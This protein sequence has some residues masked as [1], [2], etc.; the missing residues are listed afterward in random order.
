VALFAWKTTQVAAITSG[1]SPSAGDQEITI[2]GIGTPLA[3]IIE[4]TRALTSG[5]G[6]DHAILSAGAAD[7]T[8]EFNLGNRDRDNFAGSDTGKMSGSDGCIIIVNATG[9]TIDGQA[10][11]AAWITDGVRIN[12]SNFP[13][14]AYLLNVTFIYGTLAQV[15][16]MNIVTAGVQDQEDQF[17]GLGYDPNLA[18]FWWYRNSAGQ[19]PSAGNN[20][21]YFHHGM[22]VDAGDQ[23]GQGP[24]EQVTWNQ[25]SRDNRLASGWGMSVRD[26]CVL[27]DITQSAAGGSTFG[28]RLE[29]TTWQTGSGGIGLTTVNGTLV[30]NCIAV[31]AN[32]GKNRRTVKMVDL[33][34]ATTGTGTNK[35]I[36]TGWKPKLARVVGTS[37]SV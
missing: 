37:I 7:G 11:W 20:D 25:A 13:A 27:E 16:V 23:P 19:S 31:V 8:N 12:W 35:K 5:T 18:L 29:L 14:G 34:T 1:G 36:T 26:D 15:N 30:F 22:A 32:T 4:V 21:S 10:S 3:V 2:S 33:D 28:T 24:T 6:A 17:S 9:N